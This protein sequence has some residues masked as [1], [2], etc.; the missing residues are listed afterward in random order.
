MTESIKFCRSTHATLPTNR[1]SEQDLRQGSLLE[2]SSRYTLGGRSTDSVTAK[3]KHSSG[4][5]SLRSAAEKVKRKIKQGVIRATQKVKGKLTESDGKVARLDSYA[6]DYVLR[7]IKPGQQIEIHLK[8][9]FDGYL[10]LLNARNHREL[11]YGDNTS[12]NTNARMVFEAKP[13]MKYLVRVSSFDP[14]DTGKYTLRSYVGTQN[15]SNFDFFSGYGLV[16]ASAA[17]AQAKGQALFTEVADLGSTDWGLDLIKAPEVW[18]QGITGEGVTVAVIDSGI[19]YNHPEL[20]SSIWT[21]SDEIANNGIDDDRNGYIDDVKGWN[22][23]NQT[24]DPADDAIDGHGTHVSGIITADRNNTGT[25]GVAYNAKIMPLKVLNRKGTADADTALVEAIYYAVNNGAKV[26]NM[27][28]GADP[29]SGI[30]S[31]LETALRYARQA[32][33]TV[34]IAAGNDR[35]DLGALQPADP[36]FSATLNDLAITVGAVNVNQQ[37]YIDS[38]PAGSAPL[39]FVVAPGVNI[40]STIPGATYNHYDGTSMATPHVAGIVALMLSANPNLTPAQIENIL[41][42]TANQESL[43]SSP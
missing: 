25:T 7:G 6:D 19:D 21:N 15:P 23:V 30:D 10:Q 5:R 42:A 14:N 3:A 13:G 37:V 40:R 39:D 33:V 17:V 34:V 32:N 18:Q 35:Q 4:D 38:N 28:L 24:N 27:S 22:F 41:V 2:Q 29:G 12:N 36:A 11:L 20:Q 26:I 16:N 9:K 8:S 43:T 31:A 1:S